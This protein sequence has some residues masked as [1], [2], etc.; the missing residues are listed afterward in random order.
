MPQS[1]TRNKHH[2]Y[3]PHRN[4]QQQT[5]LSANPKKDKRSHNNTALFF[6]AFIGLM[7]ASIGFLVYDSNWMSIII[8]ALVGGAAGYVI[9][10]YIEKVAHAQRS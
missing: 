7:G 9:G 5:S 8:G 1:R 4:H 10:N 3:H 2:G 6:T